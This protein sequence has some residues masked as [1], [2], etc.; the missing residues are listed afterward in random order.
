MSGELR[1]F[2]G[3][4]CDCDAAGASTRDPDTVLAHD[5][6]CLYGGEKD[7]RHN[8]DRCRCWEPP[9]LARGSI[10]L[11]EHDDECGFPGRRCENDQ[12]RVWVHRACGR[13]ARMRFCGC[14]GSDRGYTLDE[15]RDWWVHY[16][17]GWPTRAWF[18]R[19]GKPVPA[20]LEGVKPVTYHEF[21]VIPRNPKRPYD[22]LSDPQRRLNDKAVGSWVWD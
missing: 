18:K 17:C 16:E 1:L 11:N 4:W 20:S 3:E 7:R 9:V 2:G 19:H 22:A 14:S 6:T 12:H 21:R 8:R 5:V 15:A 10:S 13:P